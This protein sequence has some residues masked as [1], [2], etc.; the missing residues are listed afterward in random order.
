MIRMAG[1]MATA[2]L[3]CAIVHL[4][5][6]RP[7]FVIVISMDMACLTSVETGY[8]DAAGTDK[9]A[10]AARRSRHRFNLMMSVC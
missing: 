6:Q 10:R 7:C 4:L 2:G 9:S 3:N 1:F 8:R 5:S